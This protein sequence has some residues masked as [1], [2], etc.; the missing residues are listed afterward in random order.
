MDKRIEKTKKSLHAA[1]YR[2]R[3]RNTIHDIKIADL[4]R[5]AEIN[6]TTFYSHYKSIFD[7]SAE[8]ELDLI[9]KIISDIP[10]DRDYTFENPADYTKEVTLAFMKHID[11]VSVLFGREDLPRLVF[12]LEQAMK[13]AIFAKHPHLKSNQELNVLLSYCIHGAF[14]ASLRNPE[15]PLETRMAV[16][17]AITTTL[18]PLMTPN[19]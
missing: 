6:K 17:E 13:G 7:L 4:C 14:N 15:V 1:F 16:L 12:R 19:F 5:E 18:Q 10:R 3:A 8:V 9:R 2:L 11:E